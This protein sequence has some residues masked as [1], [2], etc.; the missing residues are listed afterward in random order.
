MPK[1][2]LKLL[3][4]SFALPLAACGGEERDSSSNT[5]NTNAQPTEPA[6]GVV[7]AQPAAS[8]SEPVAATIGGPAANLNVPSP[9]SV[10]FTV[11]E[12]RE[13]QIDATSSGA[14]AQAAL[15]LN[16]SQVAS[17]SDSGEGNN[18]RIIRFLQPGNYRLFVTEWRHRPMQAQA[19]IRQLPQLESTGNLVPG[20]PL[21]IDIPRPAGY[22]TF[23]RDA[24]REVTFTVAQ[25]GSF[26]C[27]A[28]APDDRD[29]Q[30]ALMQGDGL[31][32]AEDS[33]SGEGRNARISRRFEAGTYR[34]R[35]WDWLRRDVQITVN[36]TPN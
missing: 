21:S 34:I 18:A 24:S 16:D 1:K 23:P 33:D 4:L 22:T 27:D 2:T 13:Y 10:T 26:Q 20:T 8:P 28:T 35:V 12:A 36:C 17:D 25:A 3:A 30:M 32:I 5:T 9:P 15:Y 11:A 19:T 29:A 14:D 31:F 7:A 6:P